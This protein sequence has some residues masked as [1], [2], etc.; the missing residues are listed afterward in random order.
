VPRPTPQDYNEAIQNPWACFADPTLRAGQP[1]LTALGL[2]RPVSGGFASVYRLHSGDQD[3]AVRCFLSDVPDQQERYGVVGRYLSEH[4]LPYM[5]GFDFLPRGIHVRGDWAPILKMEWIQGIGLAEYVAANLHTPGALSYLANRWLEMVRALRAAGIAHGDL[6][7]GNVLV[8]GDELRLIDYDGMFVPTLASRISHELGHRN[9][10]HPQRVATDFDA[11][12]DNFSAW[13]IY[14]SLRALERDPD[15]WPRVA[16]AGDECLLFRRDDF[17]RPYASATLK[18]L[19]GHRDARIQALGRAFEGLL[20]RDRHDIPVLDADE[21]VAAPSRVMPARRGDA[22]TSM[23]TS[24]PAWLI[25]HVPRP[26]GAAKQARADADHGQIRDLS[27]GDA[28]WVSA[29]VTPVMI[30]EQRAFETSPAAPQQVAALSVAIVVLVL[31]AVSTTA[32]PV[33]LALLVADAALLVNYIVL[34]VCY[35]RDPAVAAQRGVRERMRREQRAVVAAQGRRKRNERRRDRLNAAETRARQALQ[36]GQAAWQEKEQAE[37]DRVQEALVSVVAESDQRRRAVAQQEQ[38]A[39]TGLHVHRAHRL[40]GYVRE[41][42]A[43]NLAE[44]NELS[45]TLRAVRDRAVRDYLRRCAIATTAIPGVGDTTRQRLGQYGLRTAADL[46]DDAVRRI[47]GI[48]PAEAMALEN[49]RQAR[50]SEAGR[51]TPAALD[52]ARVAA[53][54]SSYEPRRRAVQQHIDRERERLAG[55]AT[56]IADRYRGVRQRID[57]EQLAAQVKAGKQD[58]AIADRYSKRH[59][60]IGMDLTRLREE[61]Q[62]RY[63]ELDAEAEST[64]TQLD[65]HNWQLART[66]RELAAFEELSLGR[67]ARHALFSR[68]AA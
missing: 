22:P 53:V 64:R 36:R 47:P 1:E 46:D 54:R 42:D 30:T 14:V 24:M 29:H 8:V 33:Y 62:Q 55:E 67:Y 27:G 56:A 48:G 43:I 19:T 23:P 58:K 68:H 50:T 34:I 49:W 51:M 63:E 7:H 20:Y 32:V 10:Q 39:I 45:W 6:Q 16:E 35:R 15:L 18:R 4:S 21:P 41:L 2:P 52:P 38:D 17:E 9:Y 65:S 31:I 44:S 61:Y 66:R 26:V 57:T 25:D 59:V 12:L 60:L 40:N 11:G 3:W 13:V 5:V 28:T 37:H